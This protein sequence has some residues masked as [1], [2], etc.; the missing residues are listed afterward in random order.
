M[1]GGTAEAFAA[2]GPLFA[3]MGARAVHCGASGAGQAAK[4]CNNLILGVSM[5]A[6]C[7]AFALA[8]KLG[9]DPHA[10]YDVVSTSS[11]ACWSVTSYCPLPGV[12]PSSPADRGYL[13]GFAAELMLKDLGLGQQAAARDRRRHPARRRGDRTLPRVRRRRR[14]RPRL[15]R[16]PA[17]ASRAGARGLTRAPGKIQ[18]LSENVYSSPAGPALA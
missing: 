1:A 2:A 4:I 8:E 10:L 16:R 17:L 12:G 13:P 14:P 3:A 15:L 18:L 7:E 9:L 11:G 5:I 6:V